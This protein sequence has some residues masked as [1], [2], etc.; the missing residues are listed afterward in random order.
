MAGLSELKLF[1]TYPHTCSYLA[2]KQATTVFVDPD[3]Q[4]D[5]Q[6]FSALSDYGFRR[7]G[8]HVYRPKC[9]SC[10][11]CIPIRIPVA[12][13]HPSRAQKRCSKKNGD[14]ETR[15]QTSIDTDEHYALYERY[16]AQRHNDGDMYPPT[17]EQYRDFL[18]SHWGI[19][20]YIEL[21]KDGRL[22]G[23]STVDLLTNGVSAVYFFFDPEEAQRS[24]GVYNILHLIG[25]A[26]ELQLPFV[27]LG[28]WIRECQ[29]MSYKIA[30]RPFQIRIDEQWMQVN[31]Y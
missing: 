18:S 10:Q 9:G 4:I 11:A 2:D 7:S 1:A 12:S 17:R 31:D 14:L 30:Y 23:V 29:K 5:K 8:N 13:F 15:V 20:R 19:T 21:R 26:K 25:W 3:A 16:L 27:Y 22:I 28:Y 6:I 24:L